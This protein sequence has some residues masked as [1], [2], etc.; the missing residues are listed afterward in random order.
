MLSNNTATFSRSRFSPQHRSSE[1]IDEKY[2]L[3]NHLESDQISRLYTARHIAT[4]E[5]VH[6]RVFTSYF[7]HFISDPKSFLDKTYYTSRILKNGHMQVID[8]GETEDS[9][10][11][12]WPQE[13]LESLNEL[14]K[15]IGTI[16]KDDSLIIINEMLKFLKESYKKFK[17]PHLS[18]GCGNIYINNNGEVK[19]CDAGVSSYLLKRFPFFNIKSFHEYVAPELNRDALTNGS[20][21]SDVFVLACILYKML[22]GRQAALIGESYLYRFTFSDYETKV[23]GK[24]FLAV[25]KRMSASRPQNRYQTY[26]EAQLAIQKLLKFNGCAIEA[27]EVGANE[28]ELVNVGPKEF[29]F[30]EEFQFRLESIKNVANFIRNDQSKKESRYMFKFLFYAILAIISTFMILV[31]FTI[32]RS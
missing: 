4:K 22:T 29:I 13:R 23:L 8:M 31:K 32:E 30:S 21:A 7:T 9:F 20:R 26:S 12:V 2:I 10:Y 3:R 15:K 28:N 24:D 18:L 5:F 17:E 27:E 11:I 14:G 19:F 1:I 16:N 6:I 25:F